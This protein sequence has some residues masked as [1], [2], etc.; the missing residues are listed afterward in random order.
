[1]LLSLGR[2]HMCSH[3]LLAGPVA[4]SW[5]AAPRRR[6]LLQAQAG[7]AGQGRQSSLK[8]LSAFLT[9]SKAQERGFDAA[10]FG[11]SSDEA[12]SIATVFSRS[13]LPPAWHGLCCASWPSSGAFRDQQLPLLPA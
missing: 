10:K 11:L 6:A 5:G 3:Q 2:M 13:A 4:A 9:L 8:S 1:M 7:S 12:A